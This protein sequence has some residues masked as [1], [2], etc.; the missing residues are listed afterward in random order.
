MSYYIFENVDA[1]SLGI[2]RATIFALWTIIIICT[3]L[4]NYA[5]LPPEIFDPLGIFS[6][7][8]P[9]ATSFTTEIALSYSFLI[10]LK[11]AMIIGCLLCTVGTKY[12]RWIAIPTTLLLF[13]SDGIVKGF[14]G[15]VNHAEFGILYGAAVIS[16]FPAADQFS[17][18]HNESAKN[19]S[20]KYILPIF[21]VAFILL[22]AYSFVGINRLVNGG[23]EVFTGNS[24]VRDLLVNGAEYTKWGIYGPGHFVARSPLLLPI[25]KVGFLFVTLMEVLSPLILVNKKL[26]YVWIAIMVPFH[27]LSLITMNIFFWENLILIIALFIVLPNLKSD[28]N[29]DLPKKIKKAPST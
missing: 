9:K 6:L 3:P 29:K 23:L 21:L 18:R 13:L 22:S 27:L 4:T 12:F 14:N 19:D 10:S 1:K 15:F 24:L 28:T 8:F 5:Y 7:V 25:F 16:L 20:Q 11:I 17:I 2:L 26:L